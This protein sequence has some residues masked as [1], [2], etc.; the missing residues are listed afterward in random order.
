MALVIVR[1]ADGEDS[2]ANSTARARKASGYAKGHVALELGGTGALSATAYLSPQE[3]I[4]L[5]T[6]LIRSAGRA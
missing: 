6:K 2:A 5:G 4:K 3:A 1:T